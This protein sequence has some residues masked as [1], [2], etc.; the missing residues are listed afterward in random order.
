MYFWE[1]HIC[2]SGENYYFGNYIKYGSF[3]A[4]NFSIFFINPIWGKLKQWAKFFYILV[5][6]YIKLDGE[7]IKLFF[8]KREIEKFSS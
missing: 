5:V 3:F 2:D 1:L 6:L 4:A 7:C 8:K